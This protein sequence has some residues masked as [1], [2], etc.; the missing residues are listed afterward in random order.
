MYTF[1]PSVPVCFLPRDKDVHRCACE[2]NDVPTLS[3]VSGRGWP[4]GG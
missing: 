4:C 2:A 3:T 1:S